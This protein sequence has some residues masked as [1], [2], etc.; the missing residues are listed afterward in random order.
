MRSVAR[1]A[2][3]NQGDQS[4]VDRFALISLC[5]ILTVAFMCGGGGSQ[6]GLANLTI[7]LVA[8]G[9][10]AFQRDAFAGFWRN[11]PWVL[12]GLLAASLLLPLVQ[13]VP[14]P[15][16]VWSGLPGRDLVARSLEL[17]QSSGWTP[18]SVDPLRTFLA[19][20]GLL[21]PAIVLT[22]GWSLHL[23]RLAQIAWLVIAMGL[24]T[25]AIGSLQVTSNG[26]VAT[27]FQ[28]GG[29]T[30]LLLGTFANRNSTGLLLIF[31]LALAIALPAP[32]PHPL[33][34]PVRIGVCVLLIVAIVLTRSRT[35]FVLM[36]IPLVLG[37]IRAF[38]HSRA[39]SQTATPRSALRRPA[40]IV[41]GSALVGLAAI[42]TLFAAAP[43]RLGDTLERFQNIEEARLYIW[44][45]AAY[46]IERH[47][48]L[49]SGMGTFEDVFQVDESLENLTQRRAGR[50][51]NDYIEI[52]I[53]A[54]LPG[55]LLVAFWAVF[56]GFCSWRARLSHYR[57]L[58]WS[59][60]AFMLAVA[61]QSITDY[62]LRNQTL[63]A[64]A[65]FA[66][67]VL[68]RAAFDPKAR[69]A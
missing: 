8:L 57:W 2:G 42:A 9:A 52:A 27:I 26:T 44:E 5:A 31:A 41:A 50:A 67:L 59:G 51:H 23:S 34:V 28:E 30:S 29:P 37:L 22:V 61:L 24:V 7:Q 15:P 58:G 12:R 36:A 68:A 38:W 33:V 13:I 55:L 60:S 10:L 40:S 16:A 18:F 66:M 62:P 14:L 45:D 1:I 25:L 35:A 17:A 39:A 56:I 32:R 69:Q 4:R 11:A 64:L 53:E 3:G 65:G 54:G 20:T 19:F 43:G 47:W 48:P 49:G 63:L 6:Y 21:V 46:S